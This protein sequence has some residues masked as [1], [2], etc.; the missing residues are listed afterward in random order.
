MQK[1]GAASWEAEPRYQPIARRGHSEPL[2]LLTN[3]TNPL[4]RDWLQGRMQ[5]MS[6][7]IGAVGGRKHDAFGITLLAHGMRPLPAEAVSQ[8]FSISPA[9]SDSRTDA[10][11]G[12]ALRE[13]A[14]EPHGRETCCCLPSAKER[15]SVCRSPVALSEQSSL[16]VT[17]LNV[18]AIS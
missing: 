13:T 8:F 17:A 10:P 5:N 12:R 3:I 15:Y 1:K 2:W 4:W 6:I 14:P 18:S 9:G 16:C 7:L 11:H